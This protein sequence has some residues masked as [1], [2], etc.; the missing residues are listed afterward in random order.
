MS[1]LIV[2]RG[3]PGSGKTT[4]ARLWVAEAPEIRCRVNRD[5]FR[6][7]FHA[8]RYSGMRD[9][10]R[11]VTKA[12]YAS[13]RSLLDGGYE[14]VSDDAWLVETHFREIES[15]AHVAGATFEVWDMRDVLLD[16]CIERD[17]ARGALVGSEEIIRMYRKFVAPTVR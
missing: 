4:R 10:E 3:I 16:V 9:C 6:V 17:A 7:M 5:D 11:A 2:T 13:I 14:V 1:R 8:M 12:Q 15:V